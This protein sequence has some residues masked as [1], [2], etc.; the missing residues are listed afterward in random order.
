[1][2]GLLSTDTEKQRDKTT[3]EEKR[4]PKDE[5]YVELGEGS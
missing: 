2:P 3:G 4:V 1:M 5:K